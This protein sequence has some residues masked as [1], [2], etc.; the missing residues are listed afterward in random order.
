MYK[1]IFEGDSQGQGQGQVFSLSNEI[2][3]SSEPLSKLIRWGSW[4]EE[5]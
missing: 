3:P 4:K 1:T 2:M 5:K